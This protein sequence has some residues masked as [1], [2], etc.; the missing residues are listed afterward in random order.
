LT[1]VS[2][3]VAVLALALVGNAMATPEQR[4]DSRRFVKRLEPYAWAATALMIG[5][6][7]WAEFFY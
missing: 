6:I 4:S 2:A 7:I 3:L 5:F 1:W